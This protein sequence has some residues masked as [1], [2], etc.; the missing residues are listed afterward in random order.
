MSGIF[1]PD[2][3]VVKDTVIHGGNFC[4]LNKTD[5]IFSTKSYKTHFFKS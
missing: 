3:D 5:F 2:L 1:W 4:F